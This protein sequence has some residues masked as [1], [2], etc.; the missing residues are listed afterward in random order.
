MKKLFYIILL[1]STIFAQMVPHPSLLEKIKN[2]EIEMP[3]AL[4]HKSELRAK[5]IDA[6][7]TSDELSKQN[8]LMDKKDVER[9][10]GPASPAAGTFRAIFLFVDFSDKADQVSISFFDALIFGNTTGS[11]RGYYSEI[12]YGELDLTTVDMPSTIGWKTAPQPY[13]YYVD[14]QNGY[15]TFPAN[16]QGLARDIVQLTD[17]FV[18]FSLYD[19]DSDGQIDAL[20]IVHAGPGAEFTGSDNDI[21][22]H[23]WTIPGGY[24]TNDGVTAFRY[25][26]QPEYWQTP[27]DMTI[28]VFAHEMGH[29]VFG[30]PDLYDLDYSSY[31]TGNWSLMSG[32]SWNGFTATGGDSPAWPDA[33]DHIQ[34]RYATPTVVATDILG[35]TI[36][37]TTTQSDIYKLWKDGI[38]GTEYFL[39]QNRQQELYDSAL[40]GSGILIWHVDETQTSN[41]NEWYPGHTSSGHYRIALEQA[42][43]NYDLEKNTNP[44]DAGDPFPGT[45]NNT[46]FDDSSQPD[47]KVYDGTTTYVSVE[48][49]SASGSAMTADLK[50]SQ[51][52]ASLLVTAP[53]GGE[54]WQSGTSQK[55]QWTS[56]GVSNVNIELST[57]GGSDWFSVAIGYNATLSEFNWTVPNIPSTNCLIR[58]TDANNS[59]TVDQSNSTFIISSTP[60]IVVVSPNGG[61]SWQSGTSQKIQWTSSG[62]TNVKIELSINGGSIWT[63]IVA[64]YSAATGEYSWT[65][66]NTPSTNCFIR[67]S[68]AT[69]SATV[70]QSNSPFTIAAATNIAVVSPSGGEVWTS[71]STQKIEWTSSGVAN[72]KIELSVDGGSNWSIIVAGLSASAGEYSWTVPNT[73]STN[74]FVKI[75][76]VANTATVDQSNSSFTITAAPEIIVVNPN[77]GEQ[78]TA[79]DTVGIVWTSTSVTNV[80]IEYSLD[81]GTSWSVVTPSTPS[82]GLYLW[83]TPNSPSAECLVKISDT[84]NNTI[85]DQSDAVFTIL[86]AEIEAPLLVSP[87]NNAVDIES[88]IIFKWEKV[89]GAI[90]Y[91]LQVAYDDLFSNIVYEK[92]NIA[93][94]FFSLGSLADG[95]KYYWRVLAQGV[96]IQGDYSTAYSLITKLNAPDNLT[97]RVV[98]AP[99]PTRINLNWNDNSVTETGYFIERKGPDLIWMLHD[100]VDANETTWW[101]AVNKPANY[102]YR[103]KAVSD[104]AESEYSNEASAIVSDVDKGGSIAT[105]YTLEQNYPNPFNP[106]TQIKFGLPS[107]SNVKL[108]IYN[109]LG[110]TVAE[111]IN[112][113]MMAG[114]HIVEWNASNLPSGIYVYSI[115]ANSISGD[116]SFSSIKKMLLVK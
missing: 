110:Q 81:S 3:Y 44:G 56:S 112:T 32:G 8:S 116:Q 88:P 24:T 11:M 27:G 10:Y 47:S 61:E 100:L 72:L 99:T 107:E 5:G 13:S 46:L 65:I 39:V 96:A 83:V 91:K 97:A 38:P 1:A 59:A 30:L 82:G 7:W 37:A 93:D 68:D 48:N 52:A 63:T 9:I 14:G 102:T 26:I 115:E 79:K 87:V 66:P 58:I 16:S 12:S 113:T 25:A 98:S 43:G 35:E 55:V 111:L 86:P 69:N 108:K 50:V 106:S 70:D 34:M 76:D 28:G 95:M 73:L 71:G 80:K 54:T 53:N 49:I 85:F 92:S 109:M 74:C 45:T 40:P 77:G 75:T 36:T 41:D 60:K 57:N 6:A 2:G 15:G 19:N 114:F 17:P 64:S 90:S 94:E 22:S 78:Y 31:G 84:L 62:I 101:E 33:W 103:V 21:W 89:F 23:A 18:D 67:I 29:T 105:V 51:V 42:D 104:F 20:F 4:K